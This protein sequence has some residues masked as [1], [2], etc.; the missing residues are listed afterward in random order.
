MGMREHYMKELENLRSTLLEMGELAT[1]AFEQV[2][3]ALRNNDQIMTEYVISS[4]YVINQK[5]TSINETVT[6]IIAKQ[7]PVA[8]DLRSVIVALK[9]S[10]DLERVGDL[11]VDMAKGGKRLKKGA[12]TD[13]RIELCVLAE[14]ACDMLKKAL[15][16]YNEGNVLAA[17]R[18]AQEDDLIDT[19]YALFIRNL[20]QLVPN[21]GIVEEVT[22]LAFIGR[23]IERIADYATNIAEWIVYEANGK[24]FD[25]N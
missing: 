16:A 8:S 24:Y 2:I 10:S 6:L 14:Q 1:D 18:I 20:F 9:I 4:D 12:L 25:L 22:Q 7:Q 17:Q 21:T 19:K 3:Y 5:E 23:Y 11:A 15:R 13:E